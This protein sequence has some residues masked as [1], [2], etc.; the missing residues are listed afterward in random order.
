MRPPFSQPCFPYGSIRVLGIVCL[1]ASSTI[2]GAKFV[3]PPPVLRPA[4]SAEASKWLAIAENEREDIQDRID[5]VIYLRELKE[6][7]TADRLVKLLPAKY[8]AFTFWIVVA[9]GETKSPQAL[10]ALKK[11]YNEENFAV[12]GKIRAALQRAIRACGGDPDVP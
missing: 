12:P 9:L 6:A 10:P 8:G 1:L 4:P 7:A 11:M 3:A 2:C 5:A